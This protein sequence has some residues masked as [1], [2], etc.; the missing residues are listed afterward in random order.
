MNFLE[1]NVHAKFCGKLAVSISRSLLQEIR[2]SQQN[3]WF[4]KFQILWTLFK[5][6]E[7]VGHFFSRRNV[8]RGYEI[9]RIR[10][11]SSLRIGEALD[12]GVGG[13]LGL[14]AEH[15]V[16]VREDGHHLILEELDEEGGG[17][18][19][20]VRLVLLSTLLAR[21]KQSLVLL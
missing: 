2:V 4:N 19:H 11:H 14:V 8:I 3:L 21:L 12:L 13:G 9:L 1:E 5:P 7:I 18:V 20:A 17:Q 10:I 15:D 16:R 6:T